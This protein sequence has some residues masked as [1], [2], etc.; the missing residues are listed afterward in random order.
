MIGRH[1]NYCDSARLGLRTVRRL[2]D[3]WGYRDAIPGLVADRV[4]VAQ[5]QAYRKLGSS[6]QGG[7]GTHPVE[8]DQG[9][10][11]HS[12]HSESTRRWGCFARLEAKP[13]S[14]LVD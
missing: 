8:A 12:A 3:R 11:I 5:V 1:S 2:G 14:A 6:P 4:Q 7:E 10:E 9:R 13:R